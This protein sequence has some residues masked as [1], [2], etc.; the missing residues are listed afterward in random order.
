MNLI[1]Q[2]TADPLQEQTLILSDGS[3]VFIQM[4]FIPMQYAWVF[5]TITYG[6]FILNGL[7]ITNSPNMLYQFKN[8]LPFGIACFSQNNRE[9]TQLQDFSSGASKLYILSAA[10]VLEYQ[11]IL[12][13]GV[14]G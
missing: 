4:Y 10:E 1:Q 5:N 8:I 9:P 3:T 12:Q 14:S 7:K 13:G 11:V 6:D 2:I